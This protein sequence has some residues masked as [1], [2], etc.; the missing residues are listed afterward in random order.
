M[1]AFN[2]SVSKAER[3]T[4]NMLRLTF[5]GDD[6][7]DF[8]CGQESGYLKLALEEQGRKRMRSYTIR[9]FDD[10]AK[11]LT[12]D[13]VDHGDSGPASRWATR[14]VVG[15]SAQLHGPGPTKLVD[16][17]APWFFITG[18][19]TALPAIA[20][21]LEML[22][23]SAVGYAVIEVVSE[24]DKQVLQ[25]PQG[26]EVHWVINPTPDRQNSLLADA[27]TALPWCEED[28]SVW[29]ACEFEAMRNIRRYMRQ[30]REV[31]KSNLY[32]SSY[33]KMQASDEEN[34]KAKSSDSE[35]QI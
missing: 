33:W 28:P 30:V 17:Q 18:D 4:P 10:V 27:V 32:A 31:P 25:H 15:S 7:K 16:M 11:E 24:A 9:A 29:V 23:Q 2:V 12:L 20:V 14:A 5:S 26:I 35:A 6:L 8:P 34:K 19:M 3:L 13:F 1:A 21:N 22:P